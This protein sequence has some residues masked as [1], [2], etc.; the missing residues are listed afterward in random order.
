MKASNQAIHVLQHYS[1]LVWELWL[2]PQGRYQAHFED[3]TSQR[4]QKLDTD[5]VHSFNYIC[6][7]MEKLAW[8]EHLGNVIVAVKTNKQG[9]RT[10]IANGPP[11]FETFWRKYCIRVRWNIICND[12]RGCFQP[13]INASQGA[14]KFFPTLKSWFGDWLCQLVGPSSKYMLPVNG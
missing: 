7:N 2:N 13:C 1:D 12:C 11:L 10:K 9:L 3:L 5:V 6:H 8:P 14:S 4:A